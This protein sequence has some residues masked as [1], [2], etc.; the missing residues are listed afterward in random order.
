MRKLGLGLLPA[1]IASVPVVFILAWMSNA[2]DAYFPTAGQKITVT[3]VADDTHQ[4]PPMHWQGGEAETAETPGRWQVPWPGENAPMRLIDSDGSVLL[5]L[6]TKAP[7]STVHQRRWWNDLVGNPAGYLPRPG[8]VDA[9][10]LGLPGVEFLNFGPSWLRSWITLFFLVVI[11]A[12]LG[13]KFHWRL[14]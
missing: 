8:D 12:S 7:V 14:H 1:V 5:T 10:E 4:V 11:V 3:A 2:F 6:P 13:L 9:V